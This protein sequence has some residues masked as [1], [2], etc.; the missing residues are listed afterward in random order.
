M[1]E[2]AELS[3]TEK[4][5]VAEH[6]ESLTR[7]DT[8]EAAFK[9]FASKVIGA[10]KAETK[11]ERP[12]P[13]GKSFD[14]GKAK[15]DSPEYREWS[16]TGTVTPKA[17]AKK[18]SSEPEAKGEPK[19]STANEG[20]FIDVRA[21]VEPT[22][23]KLGERAWTERL[24]GKDHDDWMA[25]V[26][27]Q[28]KSGVDFIAKH[29]RSQEIQSGLTNLL[30]GFPQP[31]AEARFEDF[32]R[33]LSEVRNPG[34]VL[35]EIGLDRAA[36]SVFRGVSNRQEMR[37]LVFGLAGHLMTKSRSVKAAAQ[38][39]ERR[40]RAPKPPAIVGG[41]GAPAERADIA[42]ARA[43]DFKAFDA[44]QRAKYRASR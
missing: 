43:G 44:A 32:T 1:P 16:E 38:P 6:A 41:Q 10:K 35:A 5:A 22:V 3:S 39:D 7:P 20:D 28:A 31:E 27:K 25:H 8:P 14:L 11:D 13:E 18:E 40:P 36:R 19:G 26:H 29:E 37:D 15:S 30:A 33:A 24:Q 23:R 4:S 9:E 42:A 21:E 17:E 12:R 34:A 2:I